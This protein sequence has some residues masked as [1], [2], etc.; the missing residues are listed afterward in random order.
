MKASPWNY[1]SHH[2]L[3]ACVLPN[4]G[5]V[6]TGTLLRLSKKIF[7]VDQ[8]RRGKK[9]GKERERKGEARWD[10]REPHELCR[11]VGLFLLFKSSS[12]NQMDEER[13]VFYW[14]KSILFDLIAG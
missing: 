8:C 9:G 14:F 10:F 11:N 13:V 7:P 12:R 6:A 2:A 4:T 3:P 5:T 1:D